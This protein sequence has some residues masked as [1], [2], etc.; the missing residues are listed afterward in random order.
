ME[1]AVGVNVTRRSGIMDEGHSP[2]RKGSR[3]ELFEEPNPDESLSATGNYVER[4]F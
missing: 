4:R 1:E 2:R 3:F